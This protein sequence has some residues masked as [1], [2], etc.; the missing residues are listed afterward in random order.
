MLRFSSALVLLLLLFPFLV[1]AGNYTTIANGKWSNSAI[2]SGGIVPSA[3]DTATIAYTDTLDANE[4]IKKL[5]VNSGKALTINAAKTLTIYGNFTN[6]GTFTNTGV[7]S[8]LSFNGS[9]NQTISGTGTISI[10]NLTINTAASTDSVILSRAITVSDSLAITSGTLACT[11]FSIT[12]NAT[13]TFT[14]AS[15]TALVLGIPSSATLPGFPLNF[16]N[17]HISLNS[18]STV[19]YQANN[20]STG[21]TVSGI[22]YYGNLYVNT[23]SG[24]ISGGTELSANGDYS[25]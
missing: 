18:N 9:A 12:G 10:K 1:K 16:T 14:M 2:W 21:Q 7:K 13:G 24:G 3:S 5:T 8:G 15:G 4:S 19:T 22:P 17:G 25:L 11:T 23:S 20:T 6:N